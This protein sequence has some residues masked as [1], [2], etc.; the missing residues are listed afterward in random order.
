MTCRLTLILFSICLLSSC[1][2]PANTKN[3]DAVGGPG[4]IVN[5]YDDRNGNTM[6][7]IED[8]NKGD[9]FELDGYFYKTSGGSQQSFGQAALTRQCVV[10][11]YGSCFMQVPAPVGSTCYCVFP[12]G[13]YANGYAN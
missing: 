8:G 2:G 5:R 13:A 6:G 7:T 3:G 11:S 9:I 10:P 1:G 12:N 4:V